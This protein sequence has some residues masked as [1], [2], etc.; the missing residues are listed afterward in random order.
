[1]RSFCP[2]CLAERE[3][4]HATKPETY[5][6]RGERVGIAAKLLVCEE[7]GNEVFDMTLDE[8]NVRQAYAAYRRSHGLLTP[9]EIRSI[10]ERYGLSQ[11]ALARALGWGLITLQRYEKGALQDLAHDSI[12]RKI[13]EDPSLLYFQFERN[14]NQFSEAETVKIRSQLADHVVGRKRELV[15]HAYESAEEIAYSRD[16]ASRGFQQFEFIRF[17]QIV[18]CIARSGKDLFKTKLAKLLWLSDFCSYALNGASMTGL[19]YCRLPYGPAPDQ[20]QLLL[21]LLEARGIVTLEPYEF[22]S[23]SGETVLLREDPGTSELGGEELEILD[24]VISKYGRMS[25]A[26][27]SQR[28]HKETLWN[29]HVDGD[30]LPYLEA[31]G[32]KMVQALMTGEEPE[33]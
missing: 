27:L 7:C 23:Y 17:A 4:K 33:W 5:T 24:R 22:N 15:I 25:S 6:V 2:T 19:V 14:T 16:K 11:R 9:K 1:M 21:G 12:L 10:R 20:F 31:H 18:G 29:N 30:S 26:E 8:T 13:S 3:V 28:S 32:V